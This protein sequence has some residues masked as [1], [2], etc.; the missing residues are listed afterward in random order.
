MRIL[1]IC[2]MSL[3][4]ISALWVNHEIYHDD[5]RILLTWFGGCSFAIYWAYGYRWSSGGAVAATKRV[6]LLRK[7]L[8]LVAYISFNVLGAINAIYGDVTNVIFFI[9]WFIATSVLFKIK[10]NEE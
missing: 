2:F 9:F 6:I 5:I 7:L 4:F 1:F 10:I 8:L 3:M